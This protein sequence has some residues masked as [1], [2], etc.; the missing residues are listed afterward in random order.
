MSNI[1]GLECLKSDKVDMVQVKLCG[2]VLLNIVL[3][4]ERS[5]G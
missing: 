4:R 5:S 2:G 3:R 1:D